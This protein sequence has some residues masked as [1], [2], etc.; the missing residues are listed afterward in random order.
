[1]FQHTDTDTS[2]WWVVQADEKEKARLNCISH[3]LSVIRYQ[4]LTSEPL[5]L[6]ERQQDEYVRPPE[7]TQRLVPQVY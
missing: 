7:S 2:P 5:E 6:P 4:D 1:M 3:L